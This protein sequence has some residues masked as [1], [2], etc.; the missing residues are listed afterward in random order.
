MRV[1]GFNFKKISIDKKKEPTND[2]NINTDIQI[3]DIQL[4]KADLFKDQDILNI[5]YEFKITYMPDFAEVFFHGNVSLLMEKE[6]D[7]LIKKIMKSWKTKQVEEDLRLPLFNIIFAR[8]NLKSMEFE[9]AVN[10]PFHIPT[11]RFTGK[12]KE[13]KESKDI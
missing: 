1:I 6:E 11:P 10:L 5:E 9:E 12:T 8:C 3:K 2:L 7:N 13:S 4:K